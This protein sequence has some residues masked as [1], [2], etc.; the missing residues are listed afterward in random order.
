MLN[1]TPEGYVYGT[2][3]AEHCIQT[4]CD[5]TREDGWCELELVVVAMN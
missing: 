5:G 1:V 2:M 4:F 3:K